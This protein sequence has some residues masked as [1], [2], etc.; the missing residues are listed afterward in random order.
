MLLK[1]TDRQL[2]AKDEEMEKLRSRVVW[3]ER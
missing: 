3:F 1:E 2:K